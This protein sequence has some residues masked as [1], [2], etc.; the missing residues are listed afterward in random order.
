MQNGWIKLHR[1]LLDSAVF[2]NAKLLKVF[3]WALLKAAH[4][5]HEVLVGRQIVRLKPG[6]F[7]FGRNA[8][9]AELNMAPSTVYD[10]ILLLQSGGTISIKSGNKFS[11]VTVENWSLYQSEDENSGSKPGNKSATNRQ[12]IGTNN[13]NKNVKNEKKNKS[14]HFTPPTIEEVE[15][16]CKERNNGVDPQ[17]W[18]DFYSAK[19]WMI[20]KNK[21]KDWKAA[22]RTWERRDNKHQ[23]YSH[24]VSAEDYD[25]RRPIDDVPD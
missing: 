12:Q 9:A 7:I 17:K 15:A 22:I 19:G 4:K 16:Y 3:L 2:Q 24:L 14:I 1:K 20:G 13:N 23:H 10:Y 6:Q 25:P 11:V 21:M 8:A 18:Y 5:E